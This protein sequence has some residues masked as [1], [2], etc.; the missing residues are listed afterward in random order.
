MDTPSIEASSE[1][2]RVN[3]FKRL[4][5][6]HHDEELSYRC[7]RHRYGDGLEYCRDPIYRITGVRQGYCSDCIQ[8]QQAGQSNQG[9]VSPGEWVMQPL[10]ANSGSQMPLQTLHR[11]QSSSNPPLAQAQATAVTL[12]SPP[13][14]PATLSNQAN[15]DTGQARVRTHE[16]FW[17]RIRRCCWF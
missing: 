13:P 15:L 6:D 1:K 5:C 2:C 8:N 12:P 11:Y 14:P 9:E 10:S 17:T 4:R 16:G 3:R 7:G